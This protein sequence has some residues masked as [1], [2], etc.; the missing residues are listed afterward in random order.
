MPVISFMLGTWQLR[1]LKWKNNLIATSEDRLTY[2]P[3]DL[4]KNI[5]P[6]DSD[7][8]QYRRVIVKGKFDHSRE[9]FVG[10][11]VQNEMKGYILYTPL[12]RSDGGEDI[13]VERGFITDENILPHRRSLKH[14]SLPDHEVEIE[15]IIKNINPKASLT[16]EKLDPDSRLW[17]VLDV[18]DMTEFTKTMRLHVCALVDLKDHPVKTVIEVLPKPWWK[19]WASNETKEHVE[20]DRTPTEVNE[21]SKYQ[22]LKAGVPI[23][24]AASID[25]K[26][27]HLNYL[28]TWYGLC[29]ASSILLF[30][31]LKKTPKADPLK[32]KL[33]HA[34]RFS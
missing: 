21:F 25:F 10:P 11:K 18:E 12:V 34:S 32:E 3:I 30:I 2:D 24:R 9:V 7:D 27:N 26:N 22:Y 20:L 33:R 19:V 1:R 8:W 31:V 5:R 16:W 15:C 17:H 14:L 6:E 28:V 13:L 29:L 4:P 23:G